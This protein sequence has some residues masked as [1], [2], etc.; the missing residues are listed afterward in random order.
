MHYPGDDHLLI[1]KVKN[2]LFIRT[3]I[4]NRLLAPEG[5]T[6]VP[7]TY[8]KDQIRVTAYGIGG[9]VSQIVPFISSDIHS[10]PNLHRISSSLPVFHEIKLEPNRLPK[11][12]A[13][14]GPP[15]PVKLIPLAVS[16]T[17]LAQ[18]LKQNSEA[19]VKIDLPEIDIFK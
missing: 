9:I 14:Y 4:D 1:W 19:N 8:S 7:K 2:A 15:G 17:Q 18:R 3:S 12:V 13:A 6:I 16:T 11:A 5:T 10:V